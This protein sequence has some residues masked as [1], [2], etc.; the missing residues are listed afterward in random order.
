MSVTSGYN[1]RTIFK[2]KPTKGL[3]GIEIEC[4][5]NHFNKDNLFLKKNGWSYHQDHSLRGEDNAEYVFPQPTGFDEA[6]QRV[7]WLFQML[8]DEGT[9][10]DE[11]NRTSVHVHLNAQEFF[12]NR[13]VAFCGL[14]F[15]V[16]EILTEWCGDHRVGNLFCLR[17]KDAPNIVSTLKQ[18]VRNSFSK[19]FNDHFHYAA[20]NLNAL[21]KF[22][23]IEIRT[24]RGARDPEI[25][26]V[27]L[28]ILERIYN[29]SAEF[30]DPRDIPPLLSGS[31]G[32]AFFDYIVG[33]HSSRIRKDINWTDQQIRESVYEGVRLAQDACYCINWSKF[34]TAKA[35][36]FGRVA[37]PESP[38]EWWTP[39]ASDGVYNLSISTPEE[40]Y[41]EGHDEDDDFDPDWEPE[42]E[43]DEETA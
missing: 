33:N 14:W 41:P 5:G 34:E 37:K 7:K 28:D 6:R 26:L 27:W 16:E 9:I 25:I 13:L 31:G 22:G 38:T 35:D 42:P 36:P 3:V 15:I 2:R 30:P 39:V 21:N 10:L 12:A 20:L 8:E 4:E 17:A 43:Y 29:L 23:S 40:F 19:G 11:S 18:Q 1:I 32:S 24:M